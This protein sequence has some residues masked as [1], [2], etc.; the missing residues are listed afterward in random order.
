M[1]KMAIVCY[2]TGGGELP[3]RRSDTPEFYF[4]TR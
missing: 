1:T 4:F 2:L 3:Y